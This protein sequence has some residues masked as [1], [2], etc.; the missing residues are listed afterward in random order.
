MGKVTMDQAEQIR[1]EM[2]QQKEQNDKILDK[3]SQNVDKLTETVS[4]IR[5]Y[6]AEMN[7]VMQRVIVTESETKEIRAELAQVKNDMSTREEAKELQKEV[8][9][10]KPKIGLAADFVVAAKRLLWAVA[11]AVA[12]M[13]FKVVF[14]VV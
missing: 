3:L 13:I 12:V 9:D 7:A 4:E 14:D 1:R 11:A 6:Q 5:V 10:I 8:A 2:A